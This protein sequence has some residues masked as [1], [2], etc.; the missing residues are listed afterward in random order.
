VVQNKF[1][2]TP[3]SLLELCKR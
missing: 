2:S 3:S 1:V